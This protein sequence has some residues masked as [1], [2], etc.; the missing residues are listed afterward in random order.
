LLE[1]TDFHIV[2]VQDTD[3]R[4]QNRHSTG[5][6]KD[7]SAGGVGEV[8]V[9]RRVLLEIGEA[10]QLGEAAQLGLPALRDDASGLRVVDVVVV[11]GLEHPDMFFDQE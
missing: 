4:K 3:S 10:E 1:A 7:G 9:E 8:N 2:G 5:D 11:G 6:S